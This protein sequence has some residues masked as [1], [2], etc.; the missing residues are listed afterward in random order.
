MG[1][2]VK[3]CSV[4]PST[5]IALQFDLS[6]H[7]SKILSRSF[8]CTALL[9]TTRLG[10]RTLAAGHPL[11]GGQRGSQV[12]HEPEQNPKPKGLPIISDCT[13][14]HRPTFD[15]SRSFDVHKRINKSNASQP[16]FIPK[17][18]SIR[19][20]SISSP[21]SQA[22]AEE[23]GPAE[24]TVTKTDTSS[25][26]WQNDASQNKHIRNH[27]RDLVQAFHNKR[28]AEAECL[29]PRSPFVPFPCSLRAATFAPQL[30]DVW[31]LRASKAS[32]VQG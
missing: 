2:F 30:R 11:P 18:N 7:G 14:T 31:Q 13:H 6:Q 29:V 4:F 28:P 15:M 9:R 16:D 20:V 26:S 10:I 19:T 1:A 5:S 8:I 25:T 22:V 3:T 23:V 24:A 12:N 32:K 21:L 17:N 27:A